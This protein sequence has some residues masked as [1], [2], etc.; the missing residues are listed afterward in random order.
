[1][2]NQAPGWEEKFKAWREKE[3]GYKRKTETGHN[4]DHT[5]WFVWKANY[6]QYDV[7]Y[8]RVIL[9]PC[10]HRFCRLCTDTVAD[11]GLTN[12][13]VERQRML[14]PSWYR[15][16]SS[17]ANAQIVID[18]TNSAK[19]DQGWTVNSVQIMHNYYFVKDMHE[20]KIGRLEKVK[21]T[22][23]LIEWRDHGPEA[24]FWESAHMPSCAEMID[25]SIIKPKNK[26]YT[27]TQIDICSHIIV[28]TYDSSFDSAF[29]PTLNHSN[30]LFELISKNF[31]SSSRGPA[32]VL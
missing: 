18:L 21:R 10:S 24:N 32:Q 30:F 22:F 31:F 5:D 19:A 1:M 13:R 6:A 2:L 20:K 7:E 9:D 15:N 12:C 27:S 25:S 14:K 16:Q 28:F 17:A 26:W 23:N 4:A 3:D 8:T 29:E 11:S